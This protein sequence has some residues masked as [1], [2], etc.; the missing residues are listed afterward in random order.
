MKLILKLILLSIVFLCTFSSI[1]YFSFV[2]N[3]DDSLKEIEVWKDG[4]VYVFVDELIKNLT[5]NS[6]LNAT[7]QSNKQNV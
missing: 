3:K 5:P 6:S 7:L 2:G 4:S 1:L